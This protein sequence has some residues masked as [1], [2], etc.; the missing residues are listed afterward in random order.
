[1]KSSKCYITRKQYIT[2]VGK[3]ITLWLLIFTLSA[4]GASVGTAAF[5]TTGFMVEHNRKMS[6]MRDAETPSDRAFS[7]RVQQ[8]EK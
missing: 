2:K 3:R 6:I 4:C 5:G 8:W 1:M 7:N